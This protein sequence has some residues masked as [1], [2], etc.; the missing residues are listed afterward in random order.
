MAP[1][2][3]PTGQPPHPTSLPNKTNVTKSITIRIM[4]N[5]STVVEGS[6]LEFQSL[7]INQLASLLAIS[8]DA[9]TKMVARNGSILLEVEMT[10]S[11]N[12]TTDMINRAYTQLVSMLNNGS[13][14]LTDLNGTVLDIPSQSNGVLSNETK[15]YTT[16]I[17]SVT[18]AS[19]G[20]TLLLVLWILWNN[21]NNKAI[22]PAVAHL[23]RMNSQNMFRSKLSSVDNLIGNNRETP[24]DHFSTFSDPQVQWEIFQKSFNKP[25]YVWQ[26]QDEAVWA[27]VDHQVQWPQLDAPDDESV[28]VSNYKNKTNKENTNI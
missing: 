25:G 5:Y 20:T 6:E 13:L 18:A 4:N 2:T 17:I 26:S 1:P 22:I 28:P 12:T 8:T 16:I 15:T 23:E 9:F 14:V 24:N 27:G 19:L 3:F 11:V 10:S 21:K 7:M